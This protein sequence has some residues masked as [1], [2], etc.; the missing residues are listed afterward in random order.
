MTRG[1]K[2][3]VAIG[4][5]K[6]KA[7]AWG[8]TLIELITTA[9]LP[10]DFVIDDRGCSSVVRIRRLKYSQYGIAEI[11][12]SCAWEIQELRALR[13][14]EGIYR[15]LWV[16]G[17]DRTWHRYLVHNDGIEV[18]ENEGR[19]SQTKKPATSPQTDP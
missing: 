10:L 14:P 1:Y 3:V 9:P 12:R 6:R 5:A 18:L 7:V 17:T 19:G 13:L 11:Q 4:E 16:R 8:F 15:E 2:P